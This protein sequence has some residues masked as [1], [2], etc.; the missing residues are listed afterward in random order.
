MLTRERENTRRDSELL[1]G[2]FWMSELREKTVNA[3]RKNVFSTFTPYGEI[4]DKD[5][6]PRP[7]RESGEKASVYA[8][9]L[10]IKI[11]IEAWENHV[12]VG[13]VGSTSIAPTK[14]APFLL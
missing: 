7:V 3:D 5:S 1:I 4:Y 10:S 6:H 2:G 14:N 12:Y 9:T 13:S 11:D 8:Q